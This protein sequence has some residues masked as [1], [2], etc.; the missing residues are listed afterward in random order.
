MTASWYEILLAVGVLSPLISFLLLVFFGPKLGKPT[1]GWVGVVLGM[2]VPLICATVVLVGWLGESPPAREELTKGAFRLTWAMMGDVPIEVGVK[3]DSL[4]VAMFFMV[5][6]V[7]LARE[8]HRRM[9][10]RLEA[11]G[12]FHAFQLVENRRL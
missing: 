3:L 10:L 5:T 8:V 12:A 1:S 7:A 2:G 4:T 6:F 11:F 9:G